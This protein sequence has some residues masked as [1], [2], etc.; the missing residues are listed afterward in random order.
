MFIISVNTF[1]SSALEGWREHIQSLVHLPHWRSGKVFLKSGGV[2]KL[3][4]IRGVGWVLG[5]GVRICMM[6]NL[7]GRGSKGRGCPRSPL[8]NV[9]LHGV[10]YKMVQS[11]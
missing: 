9:C 8:E 1:Q 7:T 5:G 10:G 3:A 4:H 11:I 2:E 6:W